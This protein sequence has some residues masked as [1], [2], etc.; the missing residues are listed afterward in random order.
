MARYEFKIKNIQ[1]NGREISRIIVDE[2]VK[3]HKDITD[4][5]IIDLVRELDGV[6]Q[7]P[8]VYIGIITVFR[9]KKR[10]KS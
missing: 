4:D 5:L 8:E 2:H 7:A 6:E 9:D 1:I 10:K 3:K